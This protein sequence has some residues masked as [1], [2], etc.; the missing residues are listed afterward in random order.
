MKY[1]RYNAA[2]IVIVAIFLAVLSGWPVYSD[3]QTPPSRDIV[4][5]AFKN[6][7]IALVVG[8][9]NYKDPNWRPLYYAGK[10]AEDMARALEDPDIAYFDKVI[11]LVEPWETTRSGILEALNQLNNWN[12]SPEDTVLIY[13]STH[14]TLARDKDHKLRQYLVAYD[15][16]F[17]NVADTAIEFDELVTAFDRL[18]SRKKALIIASC[19][20]GMGKSELPDNI[21]EE[22]GRLK[23]GFFV[24]PIEATSEASIIIGVSAWGETA[25]EDPRL[26]HDI[27]THFFL[28]G[29]KIYDR[30]QDGAVSLSEAHDYAQRKTYYYTGGV[31]RPFAR[32]DILG[33]DPIILTGDVKKTGLPVV[34][35]Y[36]GQLDGAVISI[37]G[38]E[39]GALPDGFTTTPGWNRIKASRDGGNSIYNGLLYVRQGERV[40]M[41]RLIEL[42]FEPRLG[43]VTSY[44]AAS[45]GGLSENVLPGMVMYGLAYR[46]GAFPTKN[47][48]VLLE[49]SYGSIQW[50]ADLENDYDTDFRLEAWEANAA[51]VYSHQAAKADIFAG[52]MV[53][54]F[55]MVR[56]IEVPGKS[57]RRS[58]NTIYPGLIGGV[59]LRMSPDMHFELSNRISYHYLNIDDEMKGTFVNEVSATVYFR[60]QTFLGLFQNHQ[61]R[62]IRR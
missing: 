45:F 3:E 56:D 50:T 17:D 42:R 6:R 18:S 8:I 7:R 36:S 16:S 61:I 24:K 62:E 38:R 52:P 39:K 53:G 51:L 30:N 55:N 60:P 35:S 11:K 29:M 46:M 1:R 26:E 13:F 48:S 47:A 37:N 49:A 28:Q 41:D 54:V 25:Q 20:S 9:N 31:Q 59:K 44:R 4:Q 58:A 5:D 22:M 14:G 32:S 21:K 23:S 15:S 33:A 27:Y 2:M 34:L 43:V 57:D 12:M 40:D 10:D 19:H